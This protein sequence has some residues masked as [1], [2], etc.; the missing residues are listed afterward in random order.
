MGGLPW[1]IKYHAV[2]AFQRCR[3]IP[4]ED[5]RGKFLEED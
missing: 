1:F 4:Q 2:R 3:V 5:Q